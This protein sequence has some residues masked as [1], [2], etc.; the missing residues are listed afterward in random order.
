[1]KPASHYKSVL[2]ARLAEL[3][4]RLHKI[5]AD[6]DQPA[7]KDFEDAA[8]DA[9]NDEVLEGLGASG[10]QE[11]RMIRAALDRIEQGTFGECANCGNEISEAR[12]DAIPYA[13]VCRD[14]AGSAA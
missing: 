14:C 3:D 8:T 9:E 5:D 7:A 2:E 6:L 4:A 1:M 10:M 13:A 11:A 12:L